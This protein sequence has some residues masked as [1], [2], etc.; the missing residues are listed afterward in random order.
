M[1]CRKYQQYLLGEISAEEFASHRPTCNACREAE[2]L[3]HL[4]DRQAQE[5]PVPSAA[6]GL[7]ERIA[8][9]LEEEEQRARRRKWRL[10]LSPA[11]LLYPRRRIA[12]SF[13]AV[14]V[15]AIGIVAFLVFRPIDSGPQPRNLL[16]A[17]ALA[18]VEAVE[19]EYEQAIADLEAVALP[20]VASANTELALRYRYRLETIDTQIRR[21]RDV[22]AQDGANA[23]VRRYLLAA[24]QDKK[25]TL[26]ELAALAEE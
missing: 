17:E 19:E 5:L 2:A 15:V 12:W 4:I 23:H 7:W 1:S 10:A 22:L 26:M 18:R 25:E 3:D 6:P 16:T 9:R 14:G 13:T 24:Y 21:C 20:V 11:D 8:S